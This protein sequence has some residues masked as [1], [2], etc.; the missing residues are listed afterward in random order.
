M[1][2]LNSVQSL[3][4]GAYILL[5]ARELNFSCDHKAILTA[6]LPVFQEPTQFESRCEDNVYRLLQ[7]L[8]LT[9]SDRHP[10]GNT[11]TI[12]FLMFFEFD[13]YMINIWEESCEL[14]NSSSSFSYDELSPIDTEELI[15]LK[16]L[17][18]RIRILICLRTSYDN[19]EEPLYKLSQPSLDI[20]MDGNFIISAFN[21]GRIRQVLAVYRAISDSSFFKTKVDYYGFIKRV[22]Q[23][24]I[25]VSRTISRILNPSHRG[26]RIKFNFNNLKI[27]G[28]IEK[29][30]ACL[31]SRFRIFTTLSSCFDTGKVQELREF[32]FFWTIEGEG[33]SIVDYDEV[34]KYLKIKKVFLDFLLGHKFEYSKGGCIILTEEM[35]FL[36]N[37]EAKIYRAYYLPWC[38]VFRAYKFRILGLENEDQKRFKKS[39]MIELQEL[40][41]KM[42]STRKHRLRNGMIPRITPIDGLP[43]MGPL[44]IGFP[45]YW[46][47]DLLSAATPGGGF[48]TRKD[49]D[50]Y[51]E[52]VESWYQSSMQ[53]IELCLELY[54]ID[55]EEQFSVK[56]PGVVNID[57]HTL[58]PFDIRVDIFKKFLRPFRGPITPVT[59]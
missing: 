44:H 51:V 17:I 9:C 53:F 20:F 34:P 10:S 15:G 3:V 49:K 48:E 14:E 28:G 59:W 57:P 38:L 35:G 58:L 8:L 56:S 11:S 7:L 33:H 4:Q 27:F 21:T 24:F 46:L 12:S 22:Y 31:I 5:T 43:L 6:A 39:R 25:E 52:I 29:Q 2:D 23:W 50:I 37:V 40:Q 47:Y 19:F 30:I 36:R 32:F 54:S 42:I 26:S 13:M 55:V 16:A 45:N 18:E 1:E 41:Q